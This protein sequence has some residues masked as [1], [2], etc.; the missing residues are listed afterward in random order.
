[1]YPMMYLIQRVP[2]AICHEPAGLEASKVS[3]DD[4]SNGGKKE[5]RPRVL[6]WVLEGIWDVLE[7]RKM[8]AV[9]SIKHPKLKDSSF[10]GKSHGCC[11][12]VCRF[13]WYRRVQPLPAKEGLSAMFFPFMGVW[14]ASKGYGYFA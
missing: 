1:M 2:R 9:I 12:A 4:A 11:I 6:F 8:S 13:W 5:Q 10:S 7:H 14:T 3:R